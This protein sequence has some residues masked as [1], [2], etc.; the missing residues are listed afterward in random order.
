M[1]LRT[2]L[3]EILAIEHPIIQAPMAGATTVDLVRGSLRGGRAGWLRGIRTPSP[4]PCERRA[5][6]PRSESSALRDQPLCL[7]DTK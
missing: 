1:T 2:P 7:A 5:R 3:C 6:R 4:T